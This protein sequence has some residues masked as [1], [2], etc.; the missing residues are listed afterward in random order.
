MVYALITVLC[1]ITLGQNTRILCSTFNTMG[2]QYIQ[3]SRHT[4]QHRVHYH[5]GNRY[6]VKLFMFINTYDNWK[7]LVQ[8]LIPAL[9]VF[10]KK[11][12]L[13]MTY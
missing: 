5:E 12:S 10:R 13:S 8:A 7:K 2:Y 1:L 3:D 9:G 11:S 4:N 6:D